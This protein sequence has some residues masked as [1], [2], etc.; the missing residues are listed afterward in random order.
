MY[1]QCARKNWG[2]LTLQILHNSYYILQ[3]T[4]Q[5]NIELRVDPPPWR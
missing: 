3:D 5:I 1:E 2:P 4:L